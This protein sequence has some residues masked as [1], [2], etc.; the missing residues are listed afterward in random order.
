VGEHTIFLWWGNYIFKGKRVIFLRE[1]AAYVF[2][3]NSWILVIYNVKRVV[4][5]GSGAKQ[6]YKIWA[7]GNNVT[8][9]YMTFTHENS[10]DL[11]VRCCYC[12]TNMAANITGTRYVSIT[13]VLNRKFCRYI[14]RSFSASQP[15]RVFRC[16]SMECHSPYTL[17]PMTHFNSVLCLFLHFSCLLLSLFL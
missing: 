9:L 10:S 2:L 15:L 13:C 12:F 11:S 4:D 14:S 17:F 1:I 16:V 5:L 3:Y 8:P 6:L 7:N